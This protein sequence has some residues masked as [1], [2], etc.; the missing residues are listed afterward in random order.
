MVLA[1]DGESVAQLELSDVL[2]LLKM[3]AR[4]TRLRFRALATLRPGLLV[5]LRERQE[6]RDD[7]AS[8]DAVF[9]ESFGDADSSQ[10]TDNSSTATAADAADA[11]DLE[12]R[13]SSRL[14]DFWR[15]PFRRADGF[16]F[17]RAGGLRLGIVP[18]SPRAE[19]VADSP[20]KV[21]R[22]RFTCIGT[23]VGPLLRV[24]PQAAIRVSW[25][26]HPKALACHL[27]FARDRAVRVWKTWGGRPQRL[28]D[29]GLEFIS[30]VSGLEFAKSYVVRCRY[31]FDPSYAPAEWSSPSLPVLTLD[32]PR[33]D[34]RRASRRG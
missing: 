9:S 8:H 31:V 1:V 25:R 3:A 13:Q 21:R 10:T 32:A 12:R 28:G 33:L 16:D 4:P 6:D 18:A 26:L 19:A 22:S 30:L 14:S 27:Q 23:V 20:S 24:I 7:S 2:F 34:A 11:D 5:H 29:S 15:K 17:R